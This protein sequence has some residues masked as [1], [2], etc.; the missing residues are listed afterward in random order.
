MHSAVYVPF[1]FVFPKTINGKER[2]ENQ[3]RVASVFG[4]ALGVAASTDGV[5]QHLNVHGSRA[6]IYHGLTLTAVFCIIRGGGCPK[7]IRTKEM[8]KSYLG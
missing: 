7:K 6:C 5:E 4:L 8:F 3:N 1:P 2:I